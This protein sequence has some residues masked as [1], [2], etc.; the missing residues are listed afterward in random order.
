MKRILMLFGMM[1][2]LMTAPALAANVPVTLDGEEVDGL[3]AVV[4]ESDISYV[5]FRAFC[6]KIGNMSVAKNGQYVSADAADGS[7]SIN[8]ILGQP[9]IEANGR[10]FYTGDA[11]VALWGNTTMVPL[12]TLARAFD[13]DV[14]WNDATDTVELTS[15]DGVAVSGDTYYNAEDVYWLSR[16]IQAESGNQPLR[17]K[18]AVGTVILNRVASSMF[19]STIYGVIF[20]TRYGVQFTPVSNGSIYNTPSAESVLAAKLCLDGAR[21]A[22]DSLYFVATR[23][24][25]SSWA[26]RNRAYC[27][28]IG[29]HT[30]Y[31]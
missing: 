26:G 27:E 23:S 20:D 13:L 7:W 15:G 16:I 3:T 18:V 19:P 11:V 9:Y 6:E 29:A 24:A 28:T 4:S 1:L 10:Y 14:A 30:F 8:G 22:E 31:F 2:M 5:S 17:G 21:E 12:R 25:S